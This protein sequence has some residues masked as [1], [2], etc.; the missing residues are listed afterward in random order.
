MID[1]EALP[2]YTFA[3]IKRGCK[4]SMMAGAVGGVNLSI[5]GRSMGRAPLQE[6]I[7]LYNFADAMEAAESAGENGG[8]VALGVIGEAR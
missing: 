8:G 6:V 5:E 4:Y 1:Y 7:A 3:Q 2:D